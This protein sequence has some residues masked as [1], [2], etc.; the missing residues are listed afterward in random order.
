V[1]RAADATAASGDVAR[2]TFAR[3]AYGWDRR[4]IALSA[5]W[6]AMWTMAYS[7]DSWS[8]F[9]ERSDT[10]GDSGLAGVGVPGEHRIGPTTARIGRSAWG[11]CLHRPTG[12]QH[13]CHR[14]H[15]EKE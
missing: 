4:S 1:C 12:N 11:A 13:R 2:L 9:V 14:R 8:G 3:K 5:S 6:M 15:H 10:R 7:R